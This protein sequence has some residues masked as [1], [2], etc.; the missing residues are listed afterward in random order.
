MSGKDNVWDLERAITE[1]LIQKG[2]SD[3]S[4][5]WIYDKERSSQDNF[6]TCL[7]IDGDAHFYFWDLDGMDEL[8]QVSQQYGYFPEPINY[9]DIGFYNIAE[10]Q[11]L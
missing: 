10:F 2:V 3:D 4:F 5:R 6:A 9:I 8:D 11:A 1:F 7:M